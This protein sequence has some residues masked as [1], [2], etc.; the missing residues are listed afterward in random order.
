MT[1]LQL[2]GLTV[3]YPEA[4]VTALDG[5]DLDLARGETLALVGESGSG[6]SQVA[7]A[8]LGLLPSQARVSGSVRFDGTELTALDRPALDRIRGA[9]IGLV[10]QEPMTALD[11]LFTIGHQIALPLRAHRALSRR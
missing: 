4:G 2:R 7:L 8:I 6:K 5:L 10:F 3:R 1:L 9:R 11:P